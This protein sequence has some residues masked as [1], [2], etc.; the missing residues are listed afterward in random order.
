MDI[1]KIARRMEGKY[2]EDVQVV[3]GEDTLI[4]TLS[5]QDGEVFTV[6]MIVDSIYLEED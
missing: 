2:I 4:F 1:N 3:Y 5:A 6:E